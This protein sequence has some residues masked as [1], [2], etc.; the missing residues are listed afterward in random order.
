MCTAAVRPQSNHQSNYKKKWNY[1]FF[2]REIWIGLNVVVITA[3]SHFELFFF[4]IHSSSLF[5][6]HVICR[7]VSL[8]PLV[9][10]S[11][12]E[13]TCMHNIIV[14]W[15]RQKLQRNGK[16]E[17]QWHYHYHNSTYNYIGIYIIVEHLSVRT[18][19][20]ES[21]EELSHL[22]PYIFGIWMSMLLLLLVLVLL[23]LLL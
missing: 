3:F 12:T 14:F 21:A 23:L 16:M 13:Y 19:I 20:N 17:T 15:I 2:A 11:N 6:A 22:I 18:F 8:I 9:F 5:S 1:F 7:L 10:W 4:T